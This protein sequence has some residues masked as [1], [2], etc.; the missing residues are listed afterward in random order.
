MAQIE[1]NQEALPGIG[2]RDDFVTERG[3][4]VGVI[5]HRDGRRDLL[6]YAR[7][8]PDSCSE[9][10]TLSADEAD[11]L[12]ELLGTRRVVERLASISEQVESLQSASVTVAQD[13][14][15]VGKTLNE[16]RVRARTGAAIVA[17]WRHQLVTVSPP[18][19]FSIQAGDK[20][21]LI[22]TAEALGAAEH[23]FNGG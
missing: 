6:V 13:S 10:L 23:L 20:F 14:V 17:V 22:G 5:S 16:V 7:E 12:A 3:R 8:D 18:S 11:A 21:I 9:T 19:D 4:R 15:L 1:I 2:L